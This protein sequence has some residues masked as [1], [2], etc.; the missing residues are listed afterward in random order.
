MDY[1]GKF[2]YPSNK[3]YTKET[4]A[5]VGRKRQNDNNLNEDN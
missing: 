1:A 2:T 4:E 3:D 5:T